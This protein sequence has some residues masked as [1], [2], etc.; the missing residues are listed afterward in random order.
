M[1]EINFNDLPR[2]IQ[3]IRLQLCSIENQLENLA[4]KEVYNPNELL[5]L[6]E[7]AYY[8]KTSKSSLYR[9]TGERSI[10]FIK[11]GGKLLFEKGDLDNF[12][13]SKKQVTL[14][15]IIDNHA[16]HLN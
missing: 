4:Q 6:E 15:E 12:L 2:A 16:K 13:Q 8:L 1:I 5:T 11:C 14:T 7:A 9:W 3:L 10:S